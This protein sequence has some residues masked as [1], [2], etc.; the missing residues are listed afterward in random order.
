MLAN[1]TCPSC[2]H[3][4]WLDEG[5]MGNRQVCPSCNSPFFAGKSVAEARM[6]A[7]SAAAAAAQPSYAKT[8]IGESA[9]PIKYNCPRC[10]T[11]LEA[12]SIEAGTKKNCPNCTQRH[13]VPAQAKLES[14]APA[15]NLNK[16]MLAGDESA[17]PPRPPIKYNC[18]NCKK[19]FESPADQAGTKKNCPSCNQRFQIPAAPLAGPGTPNLNKTRL[20]TDESAGP[21]SAPQGGYAADGAR[22]SS[23]VAPGTAPAAGGAWPPYV[24][25]RNVALAIIVLL[26]LLIVVPAV[27]RNGAHADSEALAKAQLDLEKLKA[28]IA[29]KKLAVDEQARAEAD[30][31]RRNEERREKRR[32]QQQREDEEY[33]R[34]MADLDDDA[35]RAE[36]SRRRK[37]K[38]KL[39]ME[40]RE[41]ERKHKQKMDKLREE[42]EAA[43]REQDEAQ[44]KIDKQPPPPVVHYP[45][46]NPRYYWPWGW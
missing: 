32:L 3:K 12:A 46:Y 6:S 1:V 5:E 4:F 38:E 40:D 2:Q 34:R 37:A 45:P 30:E 7:S 43:K 18:P 25:P 42:R 10:K 26:L 9:P 21:V 41:D 22:G 33:R 36:E 31:D 28:E 23:P 11:A 20:A 14:M 8:M 35:R 17:A 16:T 39:D 29:L 15:P 44:Q 13:Q 27:W 24:T 19:E